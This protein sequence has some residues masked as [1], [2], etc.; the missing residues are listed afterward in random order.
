MNQVKEN[1]SEAEGVLVVE[2]PVENFASS[3][4]CCVLGDDGNVPFG[5]LDLET[6]LAVAQ[7]LS[8]DH[9]HKKMAGLA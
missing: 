5:S 7:F 4:C 6:Y 8:A 9:S 3:C 1:S 2:D